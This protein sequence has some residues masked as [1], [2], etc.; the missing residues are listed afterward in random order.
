MINPL[1]E[2]E[3]LIK[4]FMICILL[5]LVHTIIFK[6]YINDLIKDTF[7]NN[8][9]NI[10]DNGLKNKMK[11]LKTNLF[12]ETILNF[13]PKDIENMYN[14]ENPNTV[15]Y[16]KNFLS[17]LVSINI[18]LVIVMFLFIYIYKVTCNADINLLNTTITIIL[19]LIL[20]G[21]F[22]YTFFIN[23]SNKYTPILSSDLTNTFVDRIKNNLQ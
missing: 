10:V 19:V 22:E 15:H 13:I 11:N 1:N 17:N 16:N 21:Y 9:K 18:V 3:F 23:I 2:P 20:I 12:V 6:Y 7:N 4:L 8:I 14:E 5:F